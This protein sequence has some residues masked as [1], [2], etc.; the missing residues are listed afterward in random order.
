LAR[1]C[2]DINYPNRS[3]EICDHG[4]PEA[5]YQILSEDAYLIWELASELLT[6]MDADLR[7]SYFHGELKI[8]LTLNEV[9]RCGIPV[10]GQAAERIYRDTLT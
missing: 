4:Y 2:L 7:W 5:L 9:T 8:A 3:D 10:D 1:R 6:E